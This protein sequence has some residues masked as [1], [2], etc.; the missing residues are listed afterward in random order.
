[1]TLYRGIVAATAA[2]LAVIGS[3]ILP[4]SA[5]QGGAPAAAAGPVTGVR[6][7]VSEGSRA[8]YRV[9]ERLAGISF[10]SDAV[11]ITNAVTGMLVIGA[12]GSV[13]PAQSKLTVD[14]RTLKSDQDQRDGFIRGPRGLDTDKFPLA[15]FVPRRAVG[16]TWPFPATPP[17]Q[18][19]FQL[20]GD[21]TIYGNTSEVTWNVV[22]TFRRG[23]SP[24]ERLRSS[25]SRSSRSR[26]LSWPGFLA[27]TT[28]QAGNRAQDEKN[29]SVE[30]TRLPR[31]LSRDRRCRPCRRDRGSLARRRARFR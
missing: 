25:R 18:A 20:V 9:T 14:L 15:E 4:A 13:N 7:D 21:M 27:S 8:S 24:V 28:H 1:M 16:L 29:A 19:G 5:Q 11:G 26:S 31:P 23:M 12:D 6:L 3:S 30:I 17:A 10:P 22:A 2:A